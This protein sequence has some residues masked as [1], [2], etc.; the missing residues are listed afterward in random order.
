[1]DEDEG[2]NLLDAENMDNYGKNSQYKEPGFGSFL[3]C[4]GC[5]FGYSCLPIFGCCGCCYP[6]KLV[7]KGYKGVVQEFGRLKREVNDG[8][9]YVNPLTEKMT[10]INMKLQVIDL[11]KQNV[12][13]SDKLSIDIDSVLYYQIININNA[14][15]NVDNIQHAIVDLSYATLRNVVGNSTLETCLGQRK[16]IADQIKKNIEEHTKKWGVHIDSIQI[17]DIV[18]PKEIVSA[19]SST[20]TAERE[21]EAKIITA[22]ANVRAAELIKKSAD[23]LNTPASMQIRSLEVIDRLGHAPNS[24]VIFMPTDLTLQSN[25]NTNILME[26]VMHT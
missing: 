3:R 24:K 1:M 9:H 26:G 5:F 20:V 7:N 12:M 4:L 2:I 11:K 18:V 13:T 6:Y 14:L 15:F 22:N 8:M 16:I 21:A 17:K 25:F 10:L 19:L 23:I